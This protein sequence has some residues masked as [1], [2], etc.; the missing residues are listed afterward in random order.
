MSRAVLSPLRPF[1]R[2][3]KPEDE[4][5]IYDAL[6]ALYEDNNVAG[7]YT[8]ERVRECVRQGVSQCNETGAI[9]G[10]VDGADDRIAATI[11]IFPNVPW[12]S[13]D[14]MLVERWLFVRKECRKFGLHNQ[15]FDFAKLFRDEM[16]GELGRPV[17]LISSVSSKERLHSK[18]RLWSRFGRLVGAIYVVEK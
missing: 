15:L 16:A 13:E 7:G 1:V 14:A 11:G 9:V 12:Y 5:A 10:V 8:P 17:K 6:I 4:P 2:I 18:M 3:A